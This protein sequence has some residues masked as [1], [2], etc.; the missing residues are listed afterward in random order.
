MLRFKVP[1]VN[2]DVLVNGMLLVRPRGEMTTTDGLIPTGTNADH[3]PGTP[4]E[5]GGIPR[6][7]TTADAADRPRNPI[8][9]LLVD[10]DEDDYVAARDT[11]ADIPGGNYALDWVATY[12]E[13]L[14]LALQ[15]DQDLCLLDYHLGERTGLELLRELVGHG[16]TTPVVLLTGQNDRSTDLE[17]MRAGAYEYL[18]K[19]QLEPA[20][21]E[22]T[23]RYSI[24]RSRVEEELRLAK[25]AAEV[26]T[27]AK[28]SFL[29]SMSHEIRTPMNAILGMTEL[30]LGTDTSDE[31]TEYLT[32]VRSAA[33]SLLSI[34][35][36]ILDLSKIEAEKLELS[37]T[38]FSLVDL[39]DE[40]M[41]IMAARKSSDGVDVRHTID[42]DVPEILEGDP[43]RLR[44]ILVNLV[45]NA[46]KFTESGYVELQVSVESRSADNAVM[47]ME[48]EDTGQ[49]IAAELI[50]KIFEPFEQGIDGPQRHAGTG[51]GLAIS[52][53]LV[54]MMGGRIWAESQVG[55]GSTFSF[56]A[57]LGCPA[58]SYQLPALPEMKSVAAYAALVVADSVGQGRATAATLRDNGVDV[59]VALDVASAVEAIRA[60]GDGTILPRVVIVD[61]VSNAVQVVARLASQHELTSLPILVVSPGGPR[62]DAE[63]TRRAGATAYLTHPME[64]GE[65]IE[66]IAAAVGRPAND[67]ELIT[68]H[69]LRERRRTLNILVADDSGPNRAVAQRLLEKKGH[70]VT[71]VGDGSLAV[72]AA[73]AHD[74][75]LILMD[76][77]MPRMD[78]FEA[79]SLIRSHEAAASRHTPIVALT[80]QAMHG[81]RE[82]CLEAGMDDYL[83]KPFRAEELYSA[84]T[85]LTQDHTKSAEI[86]DLPPPIDMATVQEMFDGDTSILAELVGLFVDEYPELHGLLSAAVADGDFPATAKVAHRLKGS[87]GT[88]S[89]FPAME[90]AAALEQAGKA[91]DE[92]AVAKRWPEFMNEIDRLEPEVVKLTDRTLLPS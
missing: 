77:Q 57:R 54:A 21:L 16:I 14:A 63:A 82:R 79:T 12:E 23:I 49:G 3:R 34:I 71:S 24:E 39:V 50:A 58:S 85:K 41:S 51:L 80:A 17:A 36:D 33:G 64:P 46:M 27:R 5:S 22:R 29:A 18:L 10:D 40:T 61:V 11:I 13:G 70:N 60:A 66:A 55:V 84:V 72:D 67:D 28:S 62:G 38:V 53:K 47:L 68:R 81:D 26:A 89:A 19:D 4:A 25:E 32:T 20:L 83:A 90:A 69:V 15:G 56:T 8:R 45:G 43:G 92:G 91:E 9:I 86:E 37:P 88:L 75:D 42:P 52:R 7:R 73:T 31:Q 48:V 35:N 44:Q 78:G 1:T 30:C 76:V 87:L 2:T 6:V 74:F 65:L 59:L